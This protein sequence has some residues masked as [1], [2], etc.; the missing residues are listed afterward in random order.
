M[1]VV[2]ADIVPMLRAIILVTPH[3]PLTLNVQSVNGAIFIHR[4]T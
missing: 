3:L 1:S 4:Q 2:H